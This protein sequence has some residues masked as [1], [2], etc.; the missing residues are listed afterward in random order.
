[1]TTVDEAWAWLQPAFQET[2]GDIGLPWEQRRA[3]LLELLGMSDPGGHEVG[4]PVFGQLD[5][6]PEDDR[7][8]LLD[9]D[10]IDAWLLD[11]L[12]AHLPEA[13]PEEAAESDDDAYD[14][15][16]WQTY[17]TAN[18][19]SW[20]GTEESW[21]AFHE[22]FV[23]YAREQGLGNP[24]TAL[25]DYLGAQSA[26]DRIA[27]FAS[28]GV[29]IQ[30]AGTDGG[31]GWVTADQQT[32]LTGRWGN[33]WAQPLTTFLDE[34]WGP[35]WQ[36]NP[37]EHKAAWLSELVAS[38]AFTAEEPVSDDAFVAE[39]AE[40]IRQVPGYDRLSPEE[41]AAAIDAASD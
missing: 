31:F 15:S 30:Q 27:T 8:T 19:P 24:A 12:R 9:S 16:A 13:E 37:A 23:H 4:G 17:L 29:T 40:A 39:L 6:L 14:E 1:M 34:R 22:W 7:A 33:G 38:G 36:A 28:Y 21:A 5:A 20:D 41:L 26:P 2:R 10:G 32:V 3:R 25:L 18:G 11:I 35:E